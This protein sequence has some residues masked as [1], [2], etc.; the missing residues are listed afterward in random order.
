M[1]IIKT[2]TKVWSIGE[3][4]NTEKVF[5]WIRNNW[6]DLAEHEVEDMV[7]TIRAFAKF[8]GAK[9]DWSLSACGH[10]GEYVRFDIK[11]ETQVASDIFTKDELS[12]GCPFTGVCTDE[13]ILDAFRAACPEELL[14]DVL[15]DVESRILKFLHDAGEYIYSDAGLREMCEANGYEFTESGKCF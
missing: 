1:R 15:R 3:H 8:I 4:P 7:C 13:V 10:R 14:I 11:N 2:E 6:H 12:G 9:P 5:D